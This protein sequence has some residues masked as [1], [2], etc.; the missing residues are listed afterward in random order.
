MYTFRVYHLDNPRIAYL[1]VEEGNINIESGIR[2]V[3][4]FL[5]IQQ[6]IIDK[7]LLI[8]NGDDFSQ[9]GESGKDIRVAIIERVLE[10]TS[11]IYVKE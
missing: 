5:D 10:Y 7:K 1:G 8:I 6:E 11:C 9:L 3:V 2:F 4:V